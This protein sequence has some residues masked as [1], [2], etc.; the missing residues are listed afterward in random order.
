MVLVSAGLGLS[1]IARTPAQA[2]AFSP[3]ETYLLSGQDTR[4]GLIAKA[5]E[6]RES[7]VKQTLLALGNQRESELLKQSGISNRACFSREIN[8][9]TWYFVYFEYAGDKDI[10]A[11][12]KHLKP[13]R[14][15]QGS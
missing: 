9:G 8:S 5:Q 6:G 14:Q 1:H 15:R 12:P 7:E 10:F 2:L 4:V 11:L 13:L 3:Y